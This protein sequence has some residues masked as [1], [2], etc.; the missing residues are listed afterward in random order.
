MRK[1]VSLLIQKLE[2]SAN[3]PSQ[4]VNPSSILEKV[5]KLLGKVS[6][7]ANLVSKFL[8]GCIVGTMCLAILLQVTLRYVFNTGLSWPEELTVF[9]MAWMTFLGSAVAIK[10]SEHIQLDLFV[11]KLPFKARSIVFFLNKIAML[12]FVLYFTYLGIRMAS[13]STGFQSN[14]MHI[15][16]FWPRISMGIGGGLMILH[17]VYFILKDI[18][19]GIQS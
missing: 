11:N 8:L 16:L 4:E 12:L 13:M 18:R 2:S 6:D 7:L 1:E 19:K 15:S 9:M 14:A 3:P 10:Q 5:E 17:L